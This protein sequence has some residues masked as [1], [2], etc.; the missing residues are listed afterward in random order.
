MTIIVTALIALVVCA[1]GAYIRSMARAVN[2][3]EI[4]SKLQESAASLGLPVRPMTTSDRV[5]VI[6]RMLPHW[7]ISFPFYLLHQLSLYVLKAS[8]WVATQLG[9]RNVK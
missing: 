5:W 9:F 8:Y 4:N 6:V 3:D 7:L 2:F 1:F